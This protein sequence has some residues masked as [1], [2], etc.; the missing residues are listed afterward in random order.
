VLSAERPRLLHDPSQA[1]QTR[2]GENPNDFRSAGT[3]DGRVAAAYRNFAIKKLKS[4][5]AGWSI[6]RT[7][8]THSRVNP[9]SK[10]RFFLQLSV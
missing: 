1:P 8:N 4:A 9:S 10:P 6:C 2:T 3:R 7:C 5:T